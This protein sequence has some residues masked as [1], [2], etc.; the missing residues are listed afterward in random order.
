M[1]V[2]V[3]GIWISIFRT[4]PI[5]SLQPILYRQSSMYKSVYSIAVG[6]RWMMWTS[7]ITGICI[8]RCLVSG[9]INWPLSVNIVVVMLLIFIFGGCA[10]LIGLTVYLPV[11]FV[12]LVICCNASNER[13]PRLSEFGAWSPRAL[14]KHPS[15]NRLTSSVNKCNA[16]TPLPSPLP[17]GVEVSCRSSMTG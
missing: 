6:P 8:F 1:S 13:A 5:G 10:N 17:S 15:V 9:S 4:S 2:V 3:I 12:N 16:P 14:N 11:N 7:L